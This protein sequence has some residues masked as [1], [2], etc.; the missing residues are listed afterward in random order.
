MEDKECIWSGID[1]ALESP[2]KRL[3]RAIFSSVQ[4]AQEIHSFFQDVSKTDIRIYAYTLCYIN[5]NI[6][7]LKMED[8]KM[9]DDI[10]LCREWIAQNKPVSPSTKKKI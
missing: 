9:Q 6:V 7:R 8:K 10:L 4:A 3:L 1:Y 2:V 5:M